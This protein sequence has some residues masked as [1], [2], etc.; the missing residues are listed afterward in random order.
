MDEVDSL[1]LGLLVVG[2]VDY[3]TSGFSEEVDVLSRRN[4]SMEGQWL[5]CCMKHNYILVDV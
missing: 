5:L 3:Y 2:E 4:S 1:S